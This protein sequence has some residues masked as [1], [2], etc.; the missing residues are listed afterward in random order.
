MV[1]LSC[2]W[3]AWLTL[4]KRVCHCGCQSV[5]GELLLFHF[6][7]MAHCQLPASSSNAQDAGKL[8]KN[9]TDA[10]AALRCSEKRAAADAAMIKC[11]LHW[12]PSAAVAAPSA[13]FYHN[14]QQLCYFS[15]LKILSWIFAVR[16]GDLL[17]FALILTLSRCSCLTTNFSCVT[18]AQVQG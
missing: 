14:R 1:L 6:L 9:I 7:A 18:P 4:A 3:D 10:V 16:R 5:F 15:L 8:W 13:A 11:Q 12:T 17:S 2:A